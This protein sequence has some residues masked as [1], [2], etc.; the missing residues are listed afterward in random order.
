MRFELS[1]LNKLSNAY[2]HILKLY[3]IKI[4]LN[5]T[6]LKSLLYMEYR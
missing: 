1:S 2:Q 6:K 4:Y 3:Y 5:V